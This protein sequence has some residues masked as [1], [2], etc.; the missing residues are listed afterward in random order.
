VGQDRGQ[1]SK[2]AGG[3]ADQTELQLKG[4]TAASL[5]KTTTALATLHDLAKL[6]Q[7][8]VATNSVDRRNQILLTS[9]SPSETTSELPLVH[10]YL[11][12]MPKE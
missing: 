3:V 11:D 1:N 5:V 6:L 12:W 2:I 7:L 4:N 10:Q 8:P 9:Q